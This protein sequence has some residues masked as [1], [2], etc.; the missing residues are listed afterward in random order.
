[1]YAETASGFFRLDQITISGWLQW[2]R[3]RERPLYYVMQNSMTQSAFAG[4]LIIPG[5]RDGQMTALTFSPISRA[6]EIHFVQLTDKQ[7]NLIRDLA[8]RSPKADAQPALK[9]AH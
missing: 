6:I 1:V 5:P 8:V 7:L 2:Q 4:A 3:S 9:A